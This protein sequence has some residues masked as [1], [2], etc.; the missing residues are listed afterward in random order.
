MSDKFYVTTSI[1]Y[2]NAAPHV[3]FAM[4]T[5]QADVLARYH[6]FK[7][8]DTFYQTGTD[9]HGMKLV[10]TAKEKGVTFVKVSK[11][12]EAATAQKMKPI[13]DDYIKMT[14]AKGLPGEEALKFCQDFLKKNP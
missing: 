7:G 14:K 10:Q 4:E 8:D 2:V 12:D 9:E 6:R 11:E 1:A 5:I 13:L 3:G